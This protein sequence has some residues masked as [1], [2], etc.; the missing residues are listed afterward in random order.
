MRRVA[1]ELVIEGERLSSRTKEPAPKRAKAKTRG[2]LFV[3]QKHAAKRLHYDFRLEIYGV[4]KS[5]AVPKGPPLERG[6]RRLAIHVE[7]HRRLDTPDP[8]RAQAKGGQHFCQ[9]ILAAP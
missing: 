6:E 5:W 2:A 4:L 7:D 8:A 9:R 3:I 1:A